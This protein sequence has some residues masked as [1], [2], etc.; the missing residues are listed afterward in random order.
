MQ[1]INNSNEKFVAT[2]EKIILTTMYILSVNNFI[3]LIA[4]Y[5]APQVDIY[6]RSIDLT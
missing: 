3:H 6:M 1:P 5:S 4:N 2:V